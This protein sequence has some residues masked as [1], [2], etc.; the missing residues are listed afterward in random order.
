V[1]EDGRYRLVLADADGI[2]R[3]RVLEGLWLKSEWLWQEPLPPLLSILK[4]W[5]LV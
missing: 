5:K 1:L 4:E 3:S 2:V